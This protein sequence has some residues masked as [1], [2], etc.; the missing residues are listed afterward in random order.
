MN[1]AFRTNHTKKHLT[2]ATK[3]IKTTS[4]GIYQLQCQT[5]S[6]P[7]Q[8]T[9]NNRNNTGFSQHILDPGH[10][11][12]NINNTMTVFR[13]AE[14]GQYMNSRE[15]YYIQKTA[16]QNLQLHD[17]QIDY[18]NPVFETLN[19]HTPLPPPV[20]LPLSSELNILTHSPPYT[21]SHSHQSCNSNHQS[22]HQNRLQAP[23]N[24]H[25]ESRKNFILTKT[26]NLILSLD[27]IHNLISHNN[28]TVH[29]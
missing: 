11:Y 9:P 1:V 10:S 4:S 16:K 8:Y 28:F 21:H 13:T 27:T 23:T 3:T 5:C 18:H 6:E 26:Q 15:K 17:S 2:H 24:N 25:K 29:T 7:I 20:S 12:G 19:K 22:L 14:E